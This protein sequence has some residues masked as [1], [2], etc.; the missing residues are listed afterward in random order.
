MVRLDEI[1]P[2]VWDATVEVMEEA[3]R[4]LEFDGDDIV[5]NWRKDANL[6]RRERELFEKYGF[7]KDVI[8]NPTF[9]EWKQW[10]DEVWDRS[11]PSLDVTLGDPIM[12]LATCIIVLFLLNNRVPRD[13]LVLAGG[14]LFNVNHLRLCILLICPST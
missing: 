4:D 5:Y 12:P 9:Q 14:I 8:L 6:K 11:A 13:V 3:L 7:L 10:F 2:G 1:R